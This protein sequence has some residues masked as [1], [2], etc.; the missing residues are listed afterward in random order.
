MGDDNYIG[1]AC[2][3]LLSFGRGRDELDRILFVRN[4]LGLVLTR[5]VQ[6]NY[7][8]TLAEADSALLDLR[9]APEKRFQKLANFLGRNPTEEQNRLPIALLGCALAAGNSANAARIAKLLIDHDE[10]FR[11]MLA[12]GVLDAAESAGPAVVEQPLD[13]AC[14]QNR[15]TH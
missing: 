11:P 13:A 3:R 1:A 9:A 15:N 6:E 14:A 8:E 10:S 7:D 5:H 12:D 2:V 4:W